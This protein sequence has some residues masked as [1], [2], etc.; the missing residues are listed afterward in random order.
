MLDPAGHE[1]DLHEGPEF[2]R[3]LFGLNINRGGG[4]FH[5]LSERINFLNSLKLYS[6]ADA[7]RLAGAKIFRPRD[8]GAL[9]KKFFSNSGSTIALELVIKIDRATRL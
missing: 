5:P 8:Q 6:T 1:K 9:W 7:F 3:D 4:G 2:T